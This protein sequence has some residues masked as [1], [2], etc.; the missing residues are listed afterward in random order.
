MPGNTLPAVHIWLTAAA[1]ASCLV[2]LG[3]C[4][5]GQTVLSPGFISEDPSQ[6]HFFAPS[7]IDFY[8]DTG[9]H[10]LSDG[11]FWNP[12]FQ[13]EHDQTVDDHPLAGTYATR[14]GV[15]HTGNG[16]AR[17]FVTR[18]GVLGWGGTHTV[19]GITEI[20]AAGVL[21]A[22][23]FLEFDYNFS[24]TFAAYDRQWSFHFPAAE[25]VTY[26][27]VAWR[28]ALNQ[29]ATHHVGAGWRGAWF[30]DK[31]WDEW[32]GQEAAAGRGFSQVSQRTGTVFVQYDWKGVDTFSRIRFETGNDLGVMGGDDGDRFRTAMARLTY[33]HQTGGLQYRIGGVMELF[34]GATDYARTVST[35][36]GTFLVTD[37][38]FFADNSQ[39]FLG[40]NLGVSWLHHLNQMIHGELGVTLIIGPDNERIRDLFQNQAIHVPRNIPQVP[41][42]DRNDRFRFDVQLF[43]ILHFGA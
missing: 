34:T 4:A 2:G 8:P 40:L 16:P 12:M 21:P 6:N 38:L 30:Q 9:S 17:R 22:G 25:W 15:I 5:R 10:P 11:S 29:N 28:L 20:G 32:N 26:A 41:L 23:Q 3:N 7:V 37:G 33:L 19:A 43:Y 14:L 18:G 42:L 31:S 35:P 39:G 36:A 27:E 13:A 24:Q 1:M